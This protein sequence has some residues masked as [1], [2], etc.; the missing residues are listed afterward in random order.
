M[1][2]GIAT[3]ALRHLTTGIRLGLLV[4]GLVSMFV[5]SR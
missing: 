5:S 1:T 2:N 4:L 3:H